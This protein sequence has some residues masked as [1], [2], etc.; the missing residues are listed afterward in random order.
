MA[1]ERRSVGG[2]RLLWRRLRAAP[3]HTLAALGSVTGLAARAERTIARASAGCLF[4]HVGQIPRSEVAIVPGA[5]VFPDGTP[6][7]MLADRLAA[8]LALQRAGLVQR[9]LV[10]GGPAEV[11]GMRAWLARHGVEDVLADP[12]GLRTWATMQRAAAQLGAVT[13][14][15]CTQ[16]FHLPRAL[17]LAR[18]AGLQAVGLVADARRYGGEGYNASRESCARM[19]AV[20]DVALMRVVHARDRPVGRE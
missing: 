10:S 11:A 8:A 20:V 19:R 12:E 17:F 13:T 14:V 15:V 6:S 5:Y 1:G 9:V 2:A 16:R 3:L 4:E 18:A 7:D